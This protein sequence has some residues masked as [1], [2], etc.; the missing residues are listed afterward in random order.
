[1]RLKGLTLVVSCIL[2][3]L[4]SCGKKGNPVPKGLPV[5]AA[6]S[7]LKGEVRDDV[8][9]LSFSI[10]TRNMDG[11]EIKDLA[12]F[13]ILRSC[14]GCAAGF[15]LWKDIH[16]TDT[17]GYTVRSGK[18]VTYDNDLREGFD[19]GYRVF[20]QTSKG[21]LG[22]GSNTFSVKWVEPPVAPK[23]VIVQEEDSRIVLSW[24]P[25]SGLFYNVYKWEDDLYPLSPLNPSPLSAATFTDPNLQNG[26]QYRYEV[27]AVKID[28]GM[29]YEGDGTAVSAT[30]R[31]MTPPVPPA[32]IKLEKQDSAVL[33][34]WTPNGE[35]DLAGY[36]I[37]WVAAGKPVKKN[38]DLVQEPRFLDKTPGNEP[39]VSYYVTAVDKA[40]NESGPSQE[41]TIILKE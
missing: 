5:P 17:Q 38:I 39:Y 24:E 22:D 8:L 7:D 21:V 14:G 10:P 18:F 34:T 33:L 9:F 30:P 11:T 3:A 4:L 16:L 28:G 36:N 40:G 32:G 26:R 6:I 27:R 29:A 41:L 15:E 13:R 25:V 2:L 1:L 23:R 35:P 37:Y 19:Y 12:G 20:S 31:D